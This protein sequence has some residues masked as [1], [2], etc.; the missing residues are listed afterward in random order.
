MYINDFKGS[1]DVI[2]ALS[3]ATKAG[4]LPHG[5]LIQAEKGQ[6][7]GYLALLLACDITGANPENAALGKE[8]SVTVIRGE[9]ASGMIR[10]EAI[11]NLT[12]RVQYSSIGS[13][14][15]A[16]IIENREN[17]NPSSA[18][19]MLKSLEEPK[20]DI[21][22][23]LTTNSP[24][25]VLPTIR[26]RCSVYTL[27]SPSRQEVSDYFAADYDPARVNRLMDSYGPN[28]GK[29]KACLEDED[30][31]SVL[32]AAGLAVIAAEKGDKYSF[33]KAAF[34]C[35]ANRQ[36]ARMFLQDIRDI[37]RIQL[38]DKRV[39]MIQLRQ[40]YEEYLSRNTNINL[41]FENFCAQATA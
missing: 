33:S 18:N 22:Y 26:S 12:R 39:R 31:Y 2:Q 14:K 16:I 17:F 24:Q 11:R 36:K 5:L 30:R 41:L 28:I 1:G 13:E 27:Q 15:R 19:A 8:E 7:A 29:I 3:Q 23:I 32:K 6:G 9:G 25:R 4:S 40:Q 38:S 37:C 35:S 20:S 10:V 21:T 34:T